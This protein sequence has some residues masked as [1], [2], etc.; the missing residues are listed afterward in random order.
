M[1]I[2]VGRMCWFARGGSLQSPFVSNSISV[3]VEIWLCCCWVGKHFVFLT[4]SKTSK[5]IYLVLWGHD[6]LFRTHCF[7]CC[8]KQVII[9]P[10]SHRGV[11]NLTTP[12]NIANYSVFSLGNMCFLLFDFLVR[13]SAWLNMWS[14]SPVRLSVCPPVCLSACSS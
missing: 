5:S 6:I 4:H 2:W 3:D 7:L 12:T 14:C 13:A 11:P 9:N 8:T 10:I 1:F